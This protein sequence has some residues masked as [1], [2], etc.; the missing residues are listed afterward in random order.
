MTLFT[1]INLKEEVLKHLD[2]TNC[3]L[4]QAQLEKKALTNT[5]VAS[6]INHAAIDT[7]QQNMGHFV[8]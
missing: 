8:G 6:T 2:K 3:I 5:Q 1:F 4:N 7:K